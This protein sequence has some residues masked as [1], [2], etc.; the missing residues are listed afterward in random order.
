M[1]LVTIIYW[2]IGWMAGW[3]GI[4]FKSKEMADE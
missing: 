1:K 3:N 2:M 4:I